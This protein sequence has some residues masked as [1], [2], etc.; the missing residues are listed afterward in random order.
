MEVTR[1]AVEAKWRGSVWEI[2][3]TPGDLGTD[4]MVRETVLGGAQLSGSVRG[5]WM[6]R[7]GPQEEARPRPEVGFGGR[8]GE[9]GGVHLEL[10]T[11]REQIEEQRDSKVHR[12]KTRERPS[13]WATARSFSPQQ[14]PRRS[15]GAGAWR[16]QGVKMGSGQGEEPCFFFKVGPLL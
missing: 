1:V 4:D 16:Q 5:V 14:G 9:P 2:I 11:P 10:E 7:Q 13:N 3:L 8:R 12:P 6:A 15:L